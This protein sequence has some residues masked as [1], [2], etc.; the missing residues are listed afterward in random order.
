MTTVSPSYNSTTYQDE[1][2]HPILAWMIRLPILFVMAGMLLSIIFMLL[3]GAFRY[4]YL[5][6]I[7]P[8]VTAFGV[9]LGGMSRDE[10]INTLSQRFTYDQTTVFTFR[11][12]DR[13]WEVTAQELGLSFDVEATVDEALAQT[14]THD[15]LN[16]LMNQARVWQNGYAVTPI[17]RYD[18]THA[19]NHL[20]RLAQVINQPAQSASIHIDENFN[21][22][23]VPP[24]SGRVLDID[25]SLTLLNNAVLA[26]NGNTEIPL[27]THETL[28]QVGS[29][30]HAIGRIETA[31]SGD[32]S[33]TAISETGE[34]LG[35]W[36]I[37]PSQIASLLKIDLVE[38]ADGTQQYMV[39]AD[40]SG[41]ANTLEQ[42]APALVTLPQDGRFQFDPITR[43]L[44]PIQAP[45][46]GRALN[47][48]A[49][50]ARL[51]NAVFNTMERDIVMVFDYV[52]P[53]YHANVTA[54][55]LGITELIGEATTYYTGSGPNRRH[56]I[57]EGTARINGVIIAPNEEFSF[58]DLVG[59][60]SFESGFKE[61]A[62]IIGN[63]TVAGVGGGICQ[64]ST[65]IFRA[66]LN[67]G[68]WITERNTHAYRVHYYELNGQPTG[69]DA[70]IWSPERDFKF[71]N[72]TPHHILIEAVISPNNSALTFR[73]YSTSIGRQVAISEPQVQNVV[74]IPST[75]YI[76]NSDL[77]AG[78][79]YQV[80][81]P[82]EG[83]DVTVTRR[84]TEA[85]GTT[86]TDRVFTHYLP[87]RAVYEVSAGDARL[88]QN[89]G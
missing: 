16:G 44:I 79:I 71:L 30:D 67:G 83:M 5:D 49:T 75:R 72:D 15:H 77:Q 65:T 6:L 47:V 12:G 66:A 48:E 80:E 57:A 31:L 33:L 28:P 9:D 7:T 4:R 11:D 39:D 78:E 58:N 23:T 45:E 52:Q 70:A 84:V 35:P 68:Y 87:W 3:I 55:E 50:L 40:L 53:R 74:A 36:T 85:D 88:G 46:V 13:T 21:I 69:L 41:F 8:G 64:V 43:Q 22:T 2:I 37:S 82:A 38:Q 54:A 73:I 10:A 32:L 20:M 34:V 18:Q 76:V 14:Q 60:I 24:Q 89:G 42:L 1:G 81:I 29:V 63:S 56:N 27:I 62:V 59:E 51:Q 19:L 86:R 25:A 17:I 61:G 26:L